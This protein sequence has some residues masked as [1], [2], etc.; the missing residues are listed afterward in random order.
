MLTLDQGIVIRSHN[1]MS[2]SLFS[3]LDYKLF[4]GSTPALIV[5]WYLQCL[6]SVWCTVESEWICIAW[7]LCASPK[8]F[9]QL[10]D[11]LKKYTCNVKTHLLQKKFKQ[12]RILECKYR[13][14]FILLLTFFLQFFSRPWDIKVL[15]CIFPFPYTAHIHKCTY[16]IQSLLPTHT[17]HFRKQNWS[18]IIGGVLLLVSGFLVN[19]FQTF[20]HS[21]WCRST[22]PTPFF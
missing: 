12:N 13:F 6:M 15:M 9:P 2:D 10:L 22:P 21:P 1:P 20:F 17:V 19:I 8:V 18:T 3:V 5:R 16:L 14:L 4:D 11:V 7:A